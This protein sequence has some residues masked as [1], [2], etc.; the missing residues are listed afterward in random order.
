MGKDGC[1]D[2][3]S[4]ARRLEL[5]LQLLRA[6]CMPGI[7]AATILFYA[8]LQMLFFA[9]RYNRKWNICLCNGYWLMVKIQKAGSPFKKSNLLVRLSKRKES[10]DTGIQ[11]LHTSFPTHSS[12]ITSI[13]ICF[14]CDKNSF[15]F[16]ISHEASK[17][18][19]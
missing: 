9:N 11:R 12:R 17:S 14:C 4:K 5:T 6:L 3:S 2:W 15:Y 16:C 10:I 8:A 13:N 18:S 19:H 7:H 1:L